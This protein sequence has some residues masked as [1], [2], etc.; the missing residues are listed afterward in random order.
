M[1][2][3]GDRRREDGK[4]SR[5]NAQK[6]ATQVKQNHPVFKLVTVV[7]A[8]ERRDYVYVASEEDRKEDEGK[9]DAIETVEITAP[10]GTVI[11][12]AKQGNVLVA[13]NRVAMYPMGKVPMYPKEELRQ[14]QEFKQRDRK[15]FDQDPSN[16]ARLVDIRDRLK[17]NYERS[18]EMFESIKSIGM[19]D[20]VEDVN[21]II[22]HLLSVGA[23][24]TVESV[25]MHP[26][27]LE[28]PLGSLRVMS[29]WKIL[30][31]GTR[32]LTTIHCMPMQ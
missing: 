26:S 17:H 12:C 11:V 9:S 25:R 16:E 21:T 20:T 32:Y 28:G 6:V 13:V 2:R 24:V 23:G 22:S 31:D 19:A 15:A 1:Q 18:Q 29:A 30:P 10:N 27:T 8:G 7:D 14:L 3:N 5:E 4:I